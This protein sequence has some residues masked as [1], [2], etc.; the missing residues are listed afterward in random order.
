VLGFDPVAYVQKLAQGNPE[1]LVVVLIASSWHLF[2]RTTRS[3]LKDLAE[4]DLALAD[5]WARRRNAWSKVP[6]KRRRKSRGVS[7]PLSGT[8]RGQR[9]AA[10]A[11][12]RELTAMSGTERG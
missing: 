11:L 12:G 4:L 8:L 1:I 7:S 10:D 5:H 3:I 6:P 9:E 2:S